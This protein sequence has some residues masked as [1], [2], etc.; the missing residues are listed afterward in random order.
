[1]QRGAHHRCCAA[2]PHRAPACGTELILTSSERLRVRSRRFLGY[3]HGLEEQEVP[4]P[5]SSAWEQLRRGQNVLALFWSSVRW[6]EMRGGAICRA[7]PANHGTPHNNTV[8][9]LLRAWTEPPCRSMRLSSA[10]F[11]ATSDRDAKLRRDATPSW[12]SSKENVTLGTSDANIGCV[13]F[14]HRVS[15][16]RRHTASSRF[17]VSFHTHREQKDARRV[18]LAQYVS[19]LGDTSSTTITRPRTNCV[20]MLLLPQGRV[21]LAR[22]S[23]LQHL[24][25]Q[26]QGRRFELLRI[27]LEEQF[28]GLGG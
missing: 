27:L 26:S 11:T 18:T 3:G 15:S 8:W 19:L 21:A 5:R 10:H 25:F 22:E 2:Q 28:Q 16:G 17:T 7:L 20:R 4:I 24:P 9:T 23:N 13:T 14:S 1:V 6:K 12:T